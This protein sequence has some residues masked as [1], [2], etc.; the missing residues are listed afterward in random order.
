MTYTLAKCVEAACGGLRI[1]DTDERLG[2][3]LA[4]H[5]EQANS[6]L[7]LSITAAGAEAGGSHGS[8]AER[9]SV[10]DSLGSL[11]SRTGAIDALR[12][13]L[14]QQLPLAAGRTM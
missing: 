9:E 2:L 1:S 12:T 4:E 11:Q 14:Y 6:L 3:D 7:D 8:V 13:A 5:A 10:D